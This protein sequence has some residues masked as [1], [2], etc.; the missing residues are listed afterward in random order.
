MKKI[1]FF[2]GN[3]DRTGGT[4][5]VGVLIANALVEKNYKISILSY[6]N[7][8]N[9]VF[10]VHPNIN[11]YSLHM[12]R[13]KDF[14]SRKIMPYVKLNNFLKE[15][16]QD[17]LV[18]IDVLLCIYSIPIKFLRKIK[19]IAWEH[20]NFTVDNGVKNR[21][22]ARKLAAYFS[23]LIVVLTKKDLDIYKSNLN[24]KK[25]ITNIYNPTLPIMNN[26]IDFQEK[27][28]IVLT[29][30]RLTEQK[31]FKELITIW[32]ELGKRTIG[33]KLIICGTGDQENALKKQIEDNK[34]DNIVMEGFCQNID[35]YYKK[36]KIFVMTSIFEGFPMVLVESQTYGL[37]I[38]SYD[39]L[40]G[41]SE[42]IIDNKNGFLIPMNDR[43][44]FKDKLIKLLNN[45]ELRD[46]FS[47]SAF[48]DCNRFKIDNIVKK[49][50][51]EINNL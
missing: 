16:P 19:I 1:C 5:R 50:E 42:I 35:E 30:G 48:N 32:S 47:I 4:E 11:L 3:I 22:R 21:K 37:P 15:N 51:D 43:S 38:V 24:I 31:N 26:M 28:N 10:K 46:I 2:S 23:D 12:E 33:W 40:T 13:N 49:W 17:I 6:E 39:C 27:E 41:P 18:N 7:G 34:L 44:L 8:M 20:F 9:P 14:F 29:I 45:K 25:R 36:A